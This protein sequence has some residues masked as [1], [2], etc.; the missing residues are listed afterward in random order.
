M[1]KILALDK[2]DRPREKLLAKGRGALTNLELLQIIIGS[3]IRGADVMHISRQVMRLI[4]AQSGRLDIEQLVHVRGVSIATATKLVASLE[5]TA[6]LAYTG[7]KIE[8]TEDVLP[9]LA[10]IRMKKQEHFVSLTVDGAHRLIE[11]RIIGVGTLNAALVHPREVF[12]DAITDRAAYIIVAHNHPSGT[13]E[14]SAADKTVTARL[15]HTGE[16]IGIELLDHIIITPTSHVS[17]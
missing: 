15:R 5:L 4:E 12:A 3:G 1:S 6:R 7:T 2:Q 9:F 16:I 17:I 11:R 14:P 8:Q 10:D 13:L